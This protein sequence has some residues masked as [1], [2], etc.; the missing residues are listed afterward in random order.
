MYVAMHQPGSGLPF[1]HYASRKLRTEA[2]EE[3]P[4]IHKEVG[5]TMTLL[6]RAG[7]AHNLDREREVA[8]ALEKLEAA[9]ARVAALEAEAQ[10]LREE[11][12]ARDDV[13][14]Q[15]NPTVSSD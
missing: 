9:N 3:L 8:A 13:M 15:Y 7:R 14:R 2:T 4:K 10:Q 12:A 6:Q 1:L 5:A 11:A